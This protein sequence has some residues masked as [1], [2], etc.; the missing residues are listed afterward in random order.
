MKQIRR[1]RIDFLRCEDL[2]S[3]TVMV[4][5]MSRCFPRCFFLRTSI[6]SCAMNGFFSFLQRW[7]SLI[8]VYSLV[9]F[10][11]YHIG[12]LVCVLENF[13]CIVL[14]DWTLILGIRMSSATKDALLRCWY[15]YFILDL[16]HPNCRANQALSSAA[17]MSQIDCLTLKLLYVEVLRRY[18][19]SRCSPRSPRSDRYI[20]THIDA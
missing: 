11:L 2:Y 3:S 7:N 20:F 14:G 15:E 17:I 13:N 4:L 5:A 8:E 12:A 10:D 9:I 6:A 16:E 19:T 1:Q 18:T